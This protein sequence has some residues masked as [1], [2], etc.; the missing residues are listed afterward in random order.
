MDWA[1]PSDAR[2]GQALSHPCCHKCLNGS[3]LLSLDPRLLLLCLFFFLWLFFVFFHLFV[4]F[5]GVIF[6]YWAWLCH[7]FHFFP[8]FVSPLYE[9]ELCMEPPQ[10]YFVKCFVNIHAHLAWLEVFAYP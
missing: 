8:F 7:F 4:L 10:V 6:I 2:A 3:G 9:R 1:T 5:L